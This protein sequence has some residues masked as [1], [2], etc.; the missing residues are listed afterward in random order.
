MLRFCNAYPHVHSNEL[1]M[2]REH[3]AQPSHMCCKPVPVA[4]PRRSAASFMARASCALIA[5][6]A[7]ICPFLAATGHVNNPGDRRRE[8]PKLHRRSKWSVWRAR[9]QDALVDLFG[10]TCP[11]T[12]SEKMAEMVIQRRL[13]ERAI[14]FSRT[15]FHDF[16]GKGAREPFR[17][18]C[19]SR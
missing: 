12:I 6:P 3:A 11:A 19:Q 2:K 7:S 5:K 17:S 1:A 18:H 8:Q 10:G 13:W 14:G 4:L 16:G 15:R 9:S